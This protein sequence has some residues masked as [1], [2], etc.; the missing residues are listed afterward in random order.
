MEI[1]ELREYVG[2][3]ETVIEWMNKEFGNDKSID[4]YKGI[5]DHSMI[6]NQLPV[7]F[8]AVEDGKL[9]GTVGIWRA[10]L[11]SR[12][13]LF[14][15]LSALIVNPQY[16]NQ[17][18]GLALQNY[19]LQYCKKQGFKEVFLYTDIDNYYEKNQWE[20]YDFGYEYSGGKVVIYKH[21][22]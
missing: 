8:V 5:V 6:E 20:Q 22:L 14:P 19:V 11:L 18:V 12:Q 1:K 9:L 15:W 10:D 16:R 21:N 7:T 17:G 4:F 2:F 3:K 13:D